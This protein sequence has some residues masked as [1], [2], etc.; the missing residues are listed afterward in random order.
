MSSQRHHISTLSLARSLAAVFINDLRTGRHAERVTRAADMIDDSRAALLFG[1]RARARG[2]WAACVYLLGAIGERLRVIGVLLRLAHL[3][4]QLTV[5]DLKLVEAVH[6][7]AQPVDR[8]RRRLAAL[9]RLR[10][11][12]SGAANSYTYQLMTS[13][14]R[15]HSSTHSSHSLL[16]ARKKPIYPR[17]QGTYQMT[18][19]PG[20][21]CC[22]SN[23]LR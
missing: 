4:L 16:I 14:S 13:A 17:V 22:V 18:L 10:L 5:L 9:A 21:S 8:V 23:W 2:G 15:G 12:L 20:T 6:H 19:V 1:E 11:D 3:V 7:V